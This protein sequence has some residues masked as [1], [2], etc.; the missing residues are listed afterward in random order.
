MQSCL[1]TMQTAWD[2]TVLLETQEQA[3]WVAKMEKYVPLVGF[4]SQLNL[5]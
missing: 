2:C 4:C 3:T 1:L 5:D